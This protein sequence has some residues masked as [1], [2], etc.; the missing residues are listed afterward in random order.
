MFFC[1]CQVI[2]AGV[3]S[4]VTPRK[5]CVGPSKISHSRSY[6]V[7]D[8]V[9]VT[10]STTSDQW[11]LG[12]LTV[13]TAGGGALPKAA[14]LAIVTTTGF[15]GGTWTGWSRVSGLAV[16]ANSS[17]PAGREPEPADCEPADCEPV[18]ATLGGATRR[19]PPR[20]GDDAATAAAAPLRARTIATTA[21]STGSRRSRDGGASDRNDESEGREGRRTVSSRAARSRG[22]PAS[23]GGRGPAS[24][25]LRR[26]EACYKAL[27]SGQNLCVVAPN[28]SPLACA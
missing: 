14:W 21:A 5:I 23:R 11:P 26:N 28:G 10:S 15:T 8:S 24:A 27:V 4:G 25:S 17:A 18:A 16:L 9:P 1:R 6:W 19:G 3:G 2:P 7:P 20:P 13:V 22:R 12:R